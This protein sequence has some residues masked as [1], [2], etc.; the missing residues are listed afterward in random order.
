MGLE[1]LVG[2]VASIFLGSGS[3]LFTTGADF[4]LV[5]RKRV[6]DSVETV[7]VCKLLL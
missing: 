7:C 1:E 3:D 6:F 4:F 2:A 5:K